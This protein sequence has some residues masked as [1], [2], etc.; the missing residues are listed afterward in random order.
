MTTETR[1]V[2]S[3]ERNVR[4]ATRERGIDAEPAAGSTECQ[5]R[6]DHHRNEEL[7]DPCG[8]PLGYP[9]AREQAERRERDGAA[10]ETQD[11]KDAK[12][13][14]RHRLQRCGDRGVPSHEAH[15]RLPRER[16]AALLDVV[17]D[18]PRVAVGRVETL[19][20]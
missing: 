5:G 1:T 10:R 2:G 12:A 18:Q 16:G 7:P 4:I 13:E 8:S 6:R 17:A 3:P 19:A 20:E 15:D 9:E 11:Q 14:L